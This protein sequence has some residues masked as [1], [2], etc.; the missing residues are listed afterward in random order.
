MTALIGSKNY[1]KTVE[2]DKTIDQPYI[3]DVQMK[4]VME[5]KQ[6]FLVV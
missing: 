6:T 3:G 2:C 4:I 1:G 5:S